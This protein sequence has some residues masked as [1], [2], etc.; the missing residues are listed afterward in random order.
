MAEEK[1]IPFAGTIIRTEPGGFGIIH[2]DHPLG[3]GTA[4]AYGIISSSSGT[5]TSSYVSV[6]EQLKPGVR[7]SG[8]ADADNQHDWATVTVIST[9]LPST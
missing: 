3:P 6:Y 4:N 5:S 1:G 7:V 9:I 2:F 8:L